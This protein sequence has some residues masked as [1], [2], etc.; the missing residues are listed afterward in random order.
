MGKQKKNS[1]NTI[2]LNRPIQNE[3]EDWIGISTYVDKLDAAV[4]ADARI[5][6]V[7]SD[8]GTGKSSLISLYKKRVEHLLII[9]LGRD[10]H[11][12]I[13][14]GLMHNR[15]RSLQINREIGDMKKKLCQQNCIRHLFI[16][17]SAGSIRTIEEKVIISAVD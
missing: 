1:N 14:G 4:D 15:R 7:T 9:P 2:Y 3:D 17:W 10:K 16:N 8:F 11:I 12:S 13:C 5:V 6:A